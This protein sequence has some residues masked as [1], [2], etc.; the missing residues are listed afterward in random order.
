[1]SIST[2]ILRSNEPL[3]D[4]EECIGF[5]P[6]SVRR[7]FT[8]WPVVCALLSCA[9]VSLLLPEVSQGSW[10]PARTVTGESAAQ[11]DF[12]QAVAPD[13]TGIVVWSK[14][15][16]GDGG[17]LISGRLVNADGTLDSA[18]EVSAADP[19]AAL[20]VASSPTV[21]YTDDTATAV[22]LESSYDSDV[23]LNDPYAPPPE[24]GEECVVTQSVK[25]RQ[26]ALD[27]TLDSIQVLDQRQTSYSAEG[28]FGGSGGAFVSYG[29]PTVAPGPGGTTTVVWSESEFAEGCAS[30][31]YA[32]EYD[33]DGCAADHAV[34]W[35]RVSA[36][37][38]P[39][40]SP[41]SLFSGHTEGA[42]SA[43]SQVRVE[44]AAA[45]D[46]TATVVLTTRVDDGDPG[47]WGGE[48]T[49]Q[50]RRIEVDASLS[51]LAEVD[52]GCG[53]AEPR[54]AVGVGG[55]SALVWAWTGDYAAGEVS[56]ARIPDGGSP[57]SPQ[58]LSAPDSGVAIA[59][60]VIA[61]AGSEA[62]AIWGAGGE[63]QART[64]PAEGAPGPV[65][66]L[67]SASGSAAYLDGLDLALASDGAGIVVWEVTKPSGG[68]SEAGVKA[69][70]LAA[71][72]T[73][74]TVRTLLS[75]HRWDHGPQVS[76]GTGD[77]F[78]AAWRLATRPD[79]RIQVSRPATG[80]MANDSF[81]GAE[82][83]AGGLPRFAAGAND[84]AT[85]EPDEPDHAGDSGGASLWYSWTPAS[86]GPVVISTCSS[87]GIDT[88]LGVYTGD[89]VDRL[90]E[91]H[92]NDDGPG[93]SCAATDSEV[94]FNAEAGTAYRVA[95]DGK[96]G[97]EGSFSLKV[98]KRPS[99]LANDDFAEPR[100]IGSFLP[101]FTSGST[102]GATKEPSEP[103]HA[104]DPGGA[105]L[106]FSWT[107]ES[108]QEVSISTCAS[109]SFDP[110][111]AV[112]TGSSLEALEQ[113]EAGD[114]GSTHP[115]CGA[116]DGEVRFRAEAG[117]TYRI[118]V[119]G[120]GGDEG[121]FTL[122][123][124]SLPANDD[125][126]DAQVLDGSFSDSA[127]ADNRLATKEPDEPDHAGH[128]G[129]A[130]VWY[131]WTP[132][133]NREVV[134]ATCSFG[135]VDPVLAV[136]TGVSLASLSP[137]ASDDNSHAGCF[138]K[139][140]ELSL[141][142]VAG[143]TYWI[144]VDSKGGIG[145]SISLS[146]ELR[147]DN[148]DFADAT[149]II[150]PL[151]Q[152]IFGW[153]SFAT[154]EPD[155]PDHAGDP[156]GAS[157]WY[158]WTAPS[159]STVSIAA[160]SFFMSPV[161]GVYTGASV[162][163]LSEVAA[164][165]E[166]SDSSCSTNR[167][168]V[169]FEAVAGT[170]YKIAV[171]G[172]LGGQGSFTLD[173]SSSP[174]NDE[175]DG[176]EVLSAS[177]PA[178]ASGNNY[179]A[180]KE[181]L[182]PDHAGHPGGASLWYS[183]TPEAAGRVAISTCSFGFDS[184]LGVYTGASLEGLESVASNDDGPDGLCEATDSEVR[185]E[186]EAETT[187][188][189]AVDGKGGG[190]PF[191]LSLYGPPGN[192]NFEQARELPA[193]LP[194]LRWS[195]NKVASKQAE[196][197][198]HDGNPGGASVWYSWTPSSSRAV[199]IALCGEGGLD[200]LL[201]VYTGE[202]FADLS[203]VAAAQ[204]G[205]DSDCAGGG[206]AVGF[207]ATAGTTYW[208]AVD[209][210]DGDEGGFELTIR[211]RAAN[212]DFAD[213]VALPASPPSGQYGDTRLAGKEP[214]EPDHAGNAGGAS[215]WYSWTPANA[216]R[217]AI[218]V[219]GFGLDPLLGVYI[220]TGL[221]DLTEV[222]GAAA[223][224]YECEGGDGEVR[225]DADAGTTYWIAVD[226][227]DGD[228]GSFELSLAGSPPND[229]FADATTLSGSLPLSAWGTNAVGAKQEH[230]PNH[231][232][233]PG[234]A[235]VWYTW[236]AS[237]DGLV[238][239]SVC[240]FGELDPLLGVY[241]G[242]SLGELTEVASANGVDGGGCF[243]DEA[244]ATFGVVAGAIYRIAVDGEGASEGEF[245]I[246][247]RTAGPTNDDFADAIE[248]DQAHALISGTTVGATV[249][250]EEG[251]S[252]WPP[253]ENTVWYR[254][255]APESGAVHLHTCSDIGGPMD[256]DVFTG[257]TVSSLSRVDSL[258]AGTG[259]A[260][261]LSPAAEGDW[262]GSTPIYAFEANAGTTYRIAIDSHFQLDPAY[263]RLSPG[264]FLL[265]FN[266]PADDL[267][268]A[269]ERIP[270]AGAGLDRSNVGAT[271]EPGEAEYIPGG[272]ASI[273]FR[274]FAS[275]DG[276]VRIDTCDSEID[277]LLG[278]LAPGDSE[279]DSSE[280]QYSDD[281]PLPEGLVIISS[282]DS[283]SCGSDSQQ[284]S[285][286]FEAREDF[287]YLIAVDGKDGAGGP[288]RLN[289]EF[290]T[291]DTTPPETNADI[292]TAI[293]S[294]ELFVTVF[295]DEPESSFE[296]ALDGAPFAA[297]EVG[298]EGYGTIVIDGLAEGTH[299]LFVREVDPAGNTDP[300]PVT[301]EFVVDGVPPE[302]SL[303]G[304]PEG[305][306][307]ELGPFT[308]N[309]NEEGRFRCWVDEVAPTTCDPPFFAPESLPDGDHVLHVRAI[310][311][312][313]NADPTPATRAFLLDRTAPVV[314]IDDGPS[315]TVESDTVGF[316]FSSEEGAV[317]RCRLDD[318]PEDDCESPRAYASLGD[319]DHV[320]SVIPIDPAGNE[321]EAATRSFR[322]ENRPPQTTIETGPAER[323]G[324][325]IANFEF[326]ADEPVDRFECSLDEA[327]FA[328]CD[329]PEELT[330]LAEGEHELRVRAVDTAGKLDP[331]PA[332]W[333]WTVDTV[334]PET[335]I[336]T[337]PSGL[338]NSRGPF[339]LDADE[340]IDHFECSLDAGDFELCGKTYWLPGAL[341]D[342]EH[343]LEARAVDLAGNTDP[344]PAER[345]L[346]LDTTGPGVE[347]VTPPPALSGPDVVVDFELD[348][349][350]TDA[351]CRIDFQSY[352][353]C[354]S[355]IEFKGIPDGPHSIF[356]RGL[357][358]LGNVGP[359]ASADF[360]VDAV[361]PETE[362]AP[363]QGDY[364]G[365]GAVAIGF[366]GSA[367]TAGFECSLDTAGF[368][369]CESP[370][371]Y[372]DLAEGIH[373]FR[374]RA[375][376]L[377][378]NA[379]PSAATLSFTVDTTP[380]E[381]T[382]TSGPSGPIHATLLP[383]EFESSE[384]PES[385]QCALDE[386]EWR[387]CAAVLKE[388]PTGEHLFA[389]RAVDRAG[390]ADPT[391]A[392]QLFTVLNEDPQPEL[393]LSKTTGPAPLAVNADVAGSDSDGDSMRYELQWG[394]GE[395]DSG[396][397][398]V[399]GLAHTYTQPGVYLV[400][401]EI[402]D[403]FSSSVATQVMTV[404]APEPLRADAGDDLVA[405]AGEPVVLDGSDSR[406]LAG[407][408]QYSWSAG[409]GA[410][411]S[412]AQFE[413]TYNDP[414]NYEA[415]LT[416]SGIAG[417]DNDVALIQ[418]VPPSGGVA[419]VLTRDDGG[420]PLEGV[421]VVLFLPNGGKVE[422]ISG[423][424]GVAR[425]R[426]LPEGSYKVFARKDGYVPNVGDLEVGA[427]GAGDGE[428][429][430]SPGDAAALAVESRRMTLE[431]IEDAGIDTSDPDNLHV[432]EFSIG[433][434]FTTYVG[435]GGILGGSGGGGGGG[436]GACIESPSSS[437]LTTV[438]S[439]WSDEAGAPIVTAMRLP[440]RATFLKEFYRLTVTVTNL[441]A[442]G[443]SLANG[444][445][446]V[447]VPS[448]MSLA[449]TPTPQ[450]AT[451]S[452]PDIPGGETETLDWILRG[453]REGEYHV[454]VSYAASLE[455]FGTAIRLEG[456]T[457]E[458][459]KV[460]GAS[461]LRLR[462]DLDDAARE[463][464][465]YTAFVELENVADVPVYN[466]TIELLDDGHLGYIEQPRQR[467]FYATRE[468]A[469]DATLTA[470]P[471]ILVPDQDGELDLSES[472][473]R[474]VA[475]DVDLGGTLVTHE[476]SPTFDETPK[477]E[478]R[479]R[480]EQDLILEWEPIPGADSYELYATP[481]L[482][483]DFP[484][485]PLTPA[486]SFGATKAM[487]SINPGEEPPLIAISALVDGVNTMAHPIVTAIQAEEEPYPSVTILDRSRCGDRQARAMVI[488][489]D[490]DFPLTSWGYAVGGEEAVPD[491]PID[492]AVEVGRTIEATRAPGQ[493][494][495]VQVAFTNT[496]PDDG[497]Q[498]RSASIGECDYVALGDSFSSGEGA[499]E[500]SEL[501]MDGGHRCHRA[502]KA[503]GNLLAQ[504]EDLDL[505]AFKPC[506]GAVTAHVKGWDG[507]VE[508]QINA[509]GGAD[510]VMLSMGGND[511]GFGT[512]LKTCIPAYVGQVLN[513]LNIFPV[514]CKV[515]WGPEIESRLPD[516]KQ[517][518]QEA[519]EDLRHR[520][521]EP[522]RV[523][524]VGYPQIFPAEKPLLSL[525]AACQM[526]HPSDIAWMHD[527]VTRVNREL[528]SVA[529]AAGA[530]FVDP[531]VDG[532]FAGN[533]VC[534]V[535]AA[536]YFNGVFLTD[537]TSP[538]QFHPNVRGQ[539][540]LRDAVENQISNPSAL[541]YVIE[542]HES[543]VDTFF[544]E[545]VRMLRAQLLWP[546][547]DVELSLESPS[548]VVYS[549][550]GAPPSAI[551]ELGPT[552]E[553]YLIPDPE[554]GEWKV[555]MTGLETD[556]G[557]EPVTLSIDQVPD[558]PI[559]PIALFSTSESGGVAPLVVQ[560]DG[561]DSFDPDDQALVYTWNFGDGG[562]ATGAITAHT[563][564]QPGEYVAELRVVDGDGQ[565]DTFE[566]DPIVVE[567]SPD[568]NPEPESES[569]G[570][571][572]RSGSPSSA[573]GGRDTPSAAPVLGPGIAVF[574]R[575][576]HARGAV[577]LIR[578]RCSGGSACRG[579]AKLVVRRRMAKRAVKRNGTRRKV[580]RVRVVPIGKGRFNVAPAQTRVIRLRLTGLGKR[581][582][583]RSGHRGL[584]AKLVGRGLRTRGVKV[585]P[586][587][588]RKKS[589]RGRAR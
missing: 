583:R 246:T 98:A 43:N 271:R 398:P 531:N 492:S 481:D 324:S 406:P 304:G 334:P 173:I 117:T 370:I 234:G 571:A 266:A 92:S 418:V 404:T 356:V 214:S 517:R 231:A 240:G 195:S 472:F 223:D 545:S 393:T 199:E 169:V 125:F 582:L 198:E 435:R 183:W 451:R 347:I 313:G 497:V 395:I 249:E 342:G 185:F 443:I 238:T 321:G 111:L 368:T 75:P 13:G 450:R 498:R 518:L 189:I 237:E 31:G 226:G 86:S 394:D 544:L 210:R 67:A 554:S 87:D 401:A 114:D 129:G 523:I 369:E 502:P 486:H 428:V 384:H 328:A 507:D 91:I 143:T 70:E 519:L 344:S 108:D 558:S 479:W 318:R 573:A 253:A 389:V 235:S 291:A 177:L 286:E 343:T 297:C 350:A 325:D 525:S 340:P 491:Q 402:D 478:G 276:P 205:T 247:L 25:A 358:E 327:G 35:I 338:T 136:Y 439:K 228:E 553:S 219:C 431:E 533:D 290:A 430:L 259:P 300:T 263:E 77:D 232:G 94:R 400:R 196:E 42:G 574:A 71:D 364:F 241:A 182:E 341:P 28:P 168:E 274:W 14:P 412:G 585:K 224:S 330:G 336:A 264:P 160:C 563:Y 181:P 118:A 499:V 388:H 66:T 414:G 268:A 34:R 9:L 59:D 407:I 361:P 152:E 421:Q 303:T 488:A 426:G 522:R 314:T 308:F 133:T 88:L 348:D 437:G 16:D 528:A 514:P 10:T 442:P 539:A 409:D 100:E 48:R 434:D 190:G 581:L 39:I 399:A 381:T 540:A 155:E 194:V 62:T 319:G 283:D 149:P 69:V 206:R 429:E 45:G 275:A 107:P 134:I 73:P 146:I 309:S 84:G 447:Q 252:S 215:L 229:E 267:R 569:S 510:L 78:L 416:V 245:E 453:D 74:G 248:I 587:G 527:M 2:C 376:D 130:S 505:L 521:L 349:D 251:T 270:T 586:Q 555:E 218:S 1:M 239:L 211:G 515:Y 110:V 277:T 56:M 482:E 438:C 89:E 187:Y 188:R 500:G 508:P 15:S 294:P 565:R 23:C 484:D 285:I 83:I 76:V 541:R 392:T 41:E 458:P 471:F 3:I 365:A 307:K 157:V 526:I 50:T 457:E 257:S 355:P 203:Q 589:R 520:P 106:W 184:L 40:G 475:G 54:L 411:G 455:P 536:A 20:S 244:E 357:D 323:V 584:R 68:T 562:E 379:D 22:W 288:I 504:R 145:G 57:E 564:T 333:A 200:P 466:P 127:S 513:P 255:T 320:F 452:V 113:V 46:G 278:A 352:Q 260:C 373:E 405:V 374:V 422:A 36:A 208:L 483:T 262:T 38:A 419:S 560:F 316:E 532:H 322:V 32:Y 516:L 495:D 123:L 58:S 97:T 326:S 360:T 269:A 547:S 459:I 282:D 464:Y 7:H 403:G 21:A 172:M 367:D 317:F 96:G 150:G 93:S 385:F 112:Y 305:L 33:G 24:P 256:I 192:D 550:E 530:E 261:E 220:G 337:G 503:Y 151:P 332:A 51:P 345:T 346:T 287:D 493:L 26:I 534:Q 468:L 408:D 186:A 281:P 436:G 329:S 217:V 462:V 580:R 315:G 164:G 446:A 440:A 433:A 135:S 126:S 487:V 201:G 417:S 242:N 473:I 299:T 371:N 383:F 576:G 529:V 568:P 293:N 396:A 191:D 52:A 61:F 99:S 377:A 222:A 63:L 140:A 233:D 441:A 298:G 310:D 490:P 354:A 79:D 535:G 119:D 144:A 556:E 29:R 273:W 557:G 496:N 230:E 227:K 476:R 448:G 202:G 250:F 420:A 474:K 335:S 577:V 161:L 105:S 410:V 148:D 386:G 542:E 366:H 579:L 216:Q 463:G 166:V 552:S 176:S 427:G 163:Q 132:E 339:G 60:P 331:T 351:E 179:L 561:S 470:G 456:E 572:A 353:P 121:F 445:A 537:L 538:E 30:Y 432:Y 158:L 312:A 171:D 415:E 53:W 546:G 18:L 153:S 213:A 178:F 204:P 85:K 197:P 306:T 489:K 124:L 95:V 167:S 575:V 147:P 103:S 295:H 467:H 8:R 193:E 301:G 4:T 82:E 444:H 494:A 131:S 570:A 44:L 180:T 506:S 174:A 162:D 55:A 460:W 469:P 137:V 465:P 109:G 102:Y 5:D 289:V 258:P 480:N 65:R 548:G 382:I 296:C 501:Y 413:H 363:G 175:F 6:R 387:G 207:T 12:G 90:S 47:C 236:Q 280:E 359:A 37:G 512:V 142:A 80:A 120:K 104:G 156:G 543:A 115:E 49:I 243:G 122:R 378:G 159:S 559:P 154:K 551:H 254:W 391:P 461:A 567:A 265:A 221:G 27:G 424:D 279:E 72:G 17:Y 284:S 209:G 578:V 566:S 272:G 141:D 170:S 549:R 397:V 101:W 511:L 64:V 390:N 372:E 139:D 138:G 509:L 425:L 128:P 423:N 524:L 477:V 212:D 81:A 454:G 362:I 485:E 375:V 292:P 225:F 165:S 588:R 11:R 311:L 19:A 380:P 116:S 302:T 449:L